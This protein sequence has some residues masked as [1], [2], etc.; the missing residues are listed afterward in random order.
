VD[1]FGRSCTAAI[2]YSLEKKPEYHCTV[3]YRFFAPEMNSFLGRI[4]QFLDVLGAG[5]DPAIIW[6]AIPFTF[7]VDWFL[8]VGDFLHS[9]RVD[10]FPFTVYLDG[11][12]ESMSA[13]I[14]RTITFETETDL[15]G[16]PMQVRESLDVY[17]RRL[18]VPY[19]YN[20]IEISKGLNVRKVLLS[21]SLIFQ[22]YSRR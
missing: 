16:Q 14:S 1:Y 7:V 3:A 21:A 4:A 8:N 19:A 12:C 6:N 10:N 18:C 15:G 11:F 13:K 17:D 2:A 20:D 9:Q 5:R 22:Q